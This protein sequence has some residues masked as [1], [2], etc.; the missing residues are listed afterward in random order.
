[1]TPLLAIFAFGQAADQDFAS[2]TR[3]LAAFEVPGPYARLTPLS[4]G[5]IQ[6]EH[7]LSV[8]AA[9]DRRFNVRIRHGH[10]RSL[11][12]DAP[13]P[14]D[15]DSDRDPPRP[16]S[17]KERLMSALSR[18]Y[19]KGGVSRVDVGT[20]GQDQH[21]YAAVLHEGRPFLA[22]DPRPFGDV[23]VQ[24]ELEARSGDLASFTDVAPRPTFDSTPPKVTG[25]QARATVERLIRVRPPKRKTQWYV[26][27]DLGDNPAYSRYWQQPEPKPVLGWYV[28]EG[29]SEARLA[30]RIPYQIRWRTVRNDT[31][32]WPTHT[33]ALLIDAA[34]EKSLDPPTE[35]EA[36]TF[37]DPA[38]K[39]A[40]PR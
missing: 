37:D 23:N 27:R 33:H 4:T 12:R 21:V 35:D 6:D 32:T 30:W 19:G 13:R 20:I 28:Q 25:A 3:I 38:A 16:I 17:H 22:K 31:V 40:G 1:M 5:P 9:G 26:G 7:D 10:V 8:G 39:V 29:A 15:S 2:A 11:Y 14:N 24:A 34:T 18:L 36:G